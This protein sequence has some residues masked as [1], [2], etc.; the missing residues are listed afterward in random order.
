MALNE[1]NFDNRPNGPD[2][3]HKFKST[4]AKR[5]MSTAA[6]FCSIAAVV[7]FQLFFIS[8]PLAGAAVILAL[9]SRGNGPV[10]GRAKIALIGGIAAFILTS[11]F[12]TYAVRT[13]YKNPALRRQMEQL[14][15]YYTGQSVGTQEPEAESPSE[16]PQQILQDILSG[17]YREEQGNAYVSGDGESGGTQNGGSF[18]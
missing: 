1:Q 16:N 17:K 8:L 13:V 12:T 18:I 2:D 4:V 15:E 5:N 6:L 11:A 9:L 7:T 14:Y 3:F 10:A